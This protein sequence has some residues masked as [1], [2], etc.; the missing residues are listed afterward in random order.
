MGKMDDIK[1]QY[2]AMDNSKKIGAAAVLTALNPIGAVALVK[3]INDAVKDSVKPLTVE[4]MRDESRD[5]PSVVVI[6]DKMIR[7]KEEKFQS[8]IA[9]FRDYG[10]IEIMHIW[11]HGVKESGL[12]FVPHSVCKGIY[13]VDPQD[14]HRYIN[15]DNLFQY[16]HNA[17]MA[18]LDHIAFHLGA[19]SYKITVLEE[20]KTNDK[21]NGSYSDAVS[22][23]GKAMELVNAGQSETGEYNSDKFMKCE[24]TNEKS[25]EGHREPTLPTLHWFKNDP[26][27]KESVSQICNHNEKP[28]HQKLE[29]KCSNSMVMS[30]DMAQ[31]VEVA[32]KKIGGKVETNLKKESKRESQSRIVFELFFE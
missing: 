23:K 10:D 6:E 1:E 4:Q 13:Y 24:G 21:V 31:K 30:V 25:F 9:W 28:Q 29:L 11:D 16:A 17:R 3:T 12:D 20:K 15:V 19:K 22:I 14:I 27:I 2:D 7:Q 18:E 5:L 26:S 32:I 8:A